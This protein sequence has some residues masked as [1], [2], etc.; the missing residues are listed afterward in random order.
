MTARIA[1][2]RRAPARGG[3]GRCGPDICSRRSWWGRCVSQLDWLEEPV[4]RGHW[5]GRGRPGR[6]TRRRRARR[7][8]GK[9]ASRVGARELRSLLKLRAKLGSQF[10]GGL[11]SALA[12]GHT[13]T[14][15][16]RSCRSAGFG[17]PSAID[18]A[19]SRRIWFAAFCPPASGV[20]ISSL[21]TSRGCGVMFSCVH[22]FP[23]WEVGHDRSGLGRSTGSMSS[24]FAGM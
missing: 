12:R 4:T 3:G 20:T 2:D 17:E 16:S 19:G 9:A 14:T 21:L 24:A 5:R 1:E 23:L 8:G 13:P 7:G 10:L 15:G 18:V 6:R 22:D 11:C